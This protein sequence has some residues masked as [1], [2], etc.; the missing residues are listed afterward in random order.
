MVALMP[1]GGITSRASGSLSYVN[2][3]R[4]FDESG[5]MRPRAAAIND[6]PIDAGAQL[7]LCPKGRR[8][9]DYQGFSN[10]GV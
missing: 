9:D 8:L 4:E 7:F 10:P 6:L 1:K 3:K 5:P 2:E